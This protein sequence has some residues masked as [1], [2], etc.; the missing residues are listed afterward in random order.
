[1]FSLALR[2]Q[3]IEYLLEE[4]EDVFSLALRVQNIEYFLMRRNQ[5][6]MGCSVFE[7]NDSVAGWKAGSPVAYRE[8]CF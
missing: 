7:N 2:V 8:T 5:F 3:N 1:M 6:C 4:R